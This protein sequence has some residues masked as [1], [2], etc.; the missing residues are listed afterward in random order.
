MKQLSLIIF[1]FSILSCQ[2]NEDSYKRISIF[3]AILKL[4]KYKNKNIEVFGYLPSF[5][6]GGY[7]HLYTDLERAKYSDWPSSIAFLA[8]TK[9]LAEYVNNSCL[10]R[11]VIVL[12]K[13][14]TNQLGEHYLLIG[15]IIELVSKKELSCE[16]NYYKRENIWTPPSQN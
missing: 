3:E 15:S 12:G 9:E 8:E 13:V 1:F 11:N 7:Y 4:E 2:A 5:K 6:L 16:Y 14:G 10:N